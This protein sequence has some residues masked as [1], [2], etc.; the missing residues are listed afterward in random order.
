HLWLIRTLSRI[1]PR[2][3]RKDW[4]EEWEAELYHRK[5]LGRSDVL[6]RSLG[7]FWDA[8]AMQPRRLEDEMFQDLRYG[9]RMLIK[10]KAL[11]VVAVLSLAIG[12]GAN[13]AVF[14]VANTVLMKKLPV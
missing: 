9:I 6:R 11:T 5:S 12:I 8:L 4:Q 14:S 13:T 1:V 10:N 2:R 7:S 3:V